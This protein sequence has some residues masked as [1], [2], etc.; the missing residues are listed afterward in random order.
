[1]KKHPFFLLLLPVFFVFHGFV[2]N[3]TF[4]SL[5]DC[6]LLL[7]IYLAGSGIVYLLSRLLLKQAMKAALFAGF[8]M[9]FFFFFGALHD[10]LRKNDLFLH[11]Y[12]VVLPFFAVVTLGL[13]FY[14]KRKGAGSR[15]PFFLNA[16]LLLYIGIDGGSLLWKALHKSPASL[17]GASYASTPMVRCDSCP[18]PDIYLLLFDD[19]SGNTTLK[20]VFNYDNSSL[21][22][23][24]EKEGFRVQKNSHSNYNFTMGSMASILNF[25]YLDNLKDIVH[26]GDYKDLLEAIAHNRV[27]NFLY[28]QG[29]SVIN[30]SPFDLP[31]QPSVRDNPLLPAKIRLITN[32]TLLNYVA[33]DLQTWVDLHLKDSTLLAGQRI[34]A[35]D[36]E[37]AQVL[38]Q[39]KAISGR[40]SDRPRFVYAHL[41]LPHFPF[42]YDSLLRRRS[43]ADVAAHFDEDQPRYYLD[44][45]P[46][47]NACAEDLITTIKKNSGG[48][49]VIIFMSDHGFRYSPNGT[50]LPWSYNNQN[51]VY[52]PDRDYGQLYDSMS[53]VNQ[54]RVILNK[55]FRQGL[56]LLKDS[57]LFLRNKE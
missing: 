15:L 9:A 22:S 30:Y 45:I 48:K 12:S 49:A 38:A 7:G 23:F 16:L 25:G 33:R 19:Y 34:A 52:F 6:L 55:L 43:S 32:R 28:T 13:F 47:T 18:R 17:T 2:E 57:A 41:L 11:K 53:N 50:P 10:F 1:M 14:L 54:F 39:T 42:F 29:Y 37:N 44:Y 35:F 24:L 36:R 3:Y 51:A 46:Y 4:I 20:E 5:T 8:I 26:P 27:V 31:G 40:R 56:P 21:D